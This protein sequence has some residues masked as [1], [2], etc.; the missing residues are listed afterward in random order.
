M[1][2]PISGVFRPTPTGAQPYD[3]ATW[4]VAYSGGG[5]FRQQFGEAGVDV[6]VVGDF[7]GDKKTDLAVYRPTTA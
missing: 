5:G 2:R 6:P 7:D 1:A 3:G 4:F